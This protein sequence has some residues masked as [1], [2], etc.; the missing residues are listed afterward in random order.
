MNMIR[1]DSRLFEV[2]ASVAD[3]RRLRV[4]STIGLEQSVNVIALVSRP[5]R[6][7]IM[8]QHA[9]RWQPKAPAC[10]VRMQDVITKAVTDV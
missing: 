2:P 8:R 7:L 3:A 6:M 1:N 9:H 5:G 4:A 10:N